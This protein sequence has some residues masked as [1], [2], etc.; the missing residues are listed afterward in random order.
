MTDGEP[1]LAG[2]RILI[3]HEWLYTRAGAER[4]LEQLLALVPHADLLVGMV[5]PE[6]RRSYPPAKRAMESWVGKLPGARRHHRWFLPVHA[7]AF[8][9]FDTSKY[10][11]VISLSHALEKTI[12]K[13]PGAKHVCYCFSPPRYLYDLRDAYADRAPLAQRL[14]L[15]AMTAP[16]RAIDRAGAKGVDRFVCISRT[17]AG[18][19][20]RVYGRDSD[21]VYPPVSVKAETSTGR[22][23]DFLLSLG[24]LV[25]YKRV[26]LAVAAANRLG[27]RL[28]VAGDGPERDRLRKL[29]GPTV[30][31]AGEVSEAEAGRLMATCRAFVFCGE[32]DFGIAPVEANAHGAPVVAYARGGLTE[33]MQEG[34]TGVMFH[35]QTAAAVAAAV[36][37]CLSHPWDEKRLRDNAGRFS[38][39]RFR[40][41]MTTILRRL[42]E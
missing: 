15:A 26:D 22:R 1:S 32:E 28:V 16:M 18:R 24:R 17:V 8:R 31:F 10:D 21:V 33:T 19:V 4:C 20:Q 39:E 11:L 9:T 14:A 35:E 42:T 40:E 12:R 6:M 13:R 41:G 37:H 34:V 3:V 2:L 7:L 30:E 25:T 23:E 29:A 27:M 5:T 36:Y 38:P